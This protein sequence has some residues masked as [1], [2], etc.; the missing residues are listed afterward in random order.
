MYIL[1]ASNTCPFFFSS[2][3][4]KVTISNPSQAIFIQCKAQHLVQS[5]ASN[6]PFFWNY[7]MTA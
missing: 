7:L 3:K 6:G 4:A 2:E 1:R 5:N